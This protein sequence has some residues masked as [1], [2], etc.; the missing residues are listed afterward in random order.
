M[1]SVVAM[2]SRNSHF[3]SSL[4][5]RLYL[6]RFILLLIL[7]GRLLISRLLVRLLREAII[8]VVK[9]L[10][11]RKQWSPAQQKV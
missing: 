10:V 4:L 3:P 8:A 9:T 1:S 6:G 5:Y 7:S 2:M 11:L